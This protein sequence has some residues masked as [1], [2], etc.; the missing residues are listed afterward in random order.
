MINRFKQFTESERASILEGLKEQYN[1]W[2]HIDKEKHG[3]TDML[4]NLIKEDS[5]D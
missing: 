5:Y 1:I 2:K 3:L 4:F